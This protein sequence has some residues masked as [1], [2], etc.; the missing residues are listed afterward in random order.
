MSN[1]PVAWIDKNTGKPRMEGFIQT[2]HDIP[3]Y[4]QDQLEEARKLG[5]QQERALWNLSASTQEI[6]DTHP[7]K[8]HFEDEPQAEELHEILQ[9]NIELTDEEINKLWAESHE[10][11][12]AM[13]QGFTTQQHYF[14]HLN[15]K[16]L[17]D[18]LEIAQGNNNA[19]ELIPE[20]IAMLR[21]QQA[22]IEALKS[23]PVKD[24][25]KDRLRF[26]DEAFNRWLDEGISDSG[27]TVYDLVENVCEAWHGWENSQYYTH[28]VKELTN[29]EILDEWMDEPLNYD[30]EREI[31]DFA[32]AILRKAQEK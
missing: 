20:A 1:E 29:E 31:V 12:I 18:R 32:R 2:H 7:A 11:G 26:S 4:T 25:E 8:E 10:D 16:H 5:M 9:S 6:M 15:M 24:R 30:G 22:Q 14:A 17:I 23:H 21:Q 28:P 13:Q 19:E 27:H 3:L